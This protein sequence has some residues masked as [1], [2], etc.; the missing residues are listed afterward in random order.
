MDSFRPGPGTERAYRDALGRFCTGITVITCM[1]DDKP[2]A[3]TANSFSSVS[4]DPP[5]VLW[6]PAV[7]SRRHD[8]FVA[9]QRFSIHVLCEGQLELARAFA[10]DGWDFSHADWRLT[11]L[12]TPAIGGV[13][14]RL[15]CH[16][17]AAHGAGDHTIVLGRVEHVE[18]AD[19]RPLVFAAG[20]YG[21]FAERDLPNGG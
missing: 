14:T 1:V 8:P 5:L 18:T 11:D 12:G 19:G 17:H 7:N 10:K 13:L 4:L 21:G 3:M 6:S 16:H 15:D 9:A 20:T 2:L